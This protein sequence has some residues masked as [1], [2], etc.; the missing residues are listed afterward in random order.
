MYKKGVRF[1]I[2][3]ESWLQL[4]G[5]ARISSITQRDLNTNQIN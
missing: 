3:L 2:T 5:I 1:G 4:G